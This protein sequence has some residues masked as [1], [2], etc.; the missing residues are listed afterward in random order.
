MKKHKNE[1]LYW[2]IVT[3][4]ISFM[5]I[6]LLF[7]FILLF[8]FVPSQSMEPTM[9]AGSFFIASRLYCDLQ[10]GDIVALQH[11]GKLLVKRIIYSPGD[12]IDWTGFDCISDT[13]SGPW[14]DTVPEGCYI[15]MGDNRDESQDSRSWSDPFVAEDLIEAVVLG[16]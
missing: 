4:M 5:A 7:R 2:R 12:V 9:P 15:V 13:E 6:V 8:G 11:E 14:P 1:G 10:D 3:P 16:E